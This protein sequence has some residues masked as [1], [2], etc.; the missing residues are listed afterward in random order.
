MRI[1]SFNFEESSSPPRFCQL[2]FRRKIPRIFYIIRNSS[3]QS[4]Q[5]GK[6]GLQKGGGGVLEGGGGGKLQLKPLNNA[7]TNLWSYVS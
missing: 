5:R 4:F 6:V 7:Q 2:R 1:V 3:L